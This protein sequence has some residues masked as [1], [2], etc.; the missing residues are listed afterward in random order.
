[1]LLLSVQ[2]VVALLYSVTAVTGLDTAGS[3]AA[4]VNAKQCN[5]VQGIVSNL[6]KTAMSSAQAFCNVY[7]TAKM[8]TVL[9]PGPTT[10]VRVAGICAAPSVPG[11]PSST[12]QVSKRD[13]DIAKRGFVRSPAA[14]APTFLTALGTSILSKACS[15]LTQT[16]TTVTAPTSTFTL[17]TYTPVVATTTK[18]FTVTPSANT[19]YSTAVSSRI[20]TST[21]TSVVSATSISETVI[22]NTEYSTATTLDIA[23][24][25]IPSPT[26]TSTET[27]TTVVTSTETELTTVVIVTTSRLL[28]KRA[29]PSSVLT[30]CYTSTLTVST[31]VTAAT[32]TTTIPVQSV[33]DRTTQQ[34]D[35][36]TT[37]TTITS[38]LLTTI[39]RPTTVTI[40][41]TSTSISGYV[42]SEST[43]ITFKSIST[44]TVSSTTTS[45]TIQQPLRTNLVKNPSFESHPGL[46]DWKFNLTGWY[47]D[48][49]EAADGVQYVSLFVRKDK[50]YIQD[51]AI[52]YQEIDSPYLAN[53][54]H[55][56]FQWKFSYIGDSLNAYIPPKNPVACTLIAGWKDNAAFT[57]TTTITESYGTTYFSSGK[58][59]QW[60]H[61]AFDIPPSNDVS[62]TLAFKFTCSSLSS[63]VYGDL[64]IDDTSVSVILPSVSDQ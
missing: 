36:S 32:P 5:L 2:A 31:T 4:A 46:T 34:I 16:I 23:T 41:T 28:Q 7:V 14:P 9:L 33:N 47:R 50:A 11:V 59:P 30:G 48:S 54:A 27:Y 26:A 1:M 19:A 57:N 21:M 25:V 17:T 43:L 39:T 53:G 40:P 29:V 15:C 44:L 38:T 45:T 62:G 63:S 8:Q 56:T 49:E 52:L 55:V 13:V 61:G 6:P 20:L 12:P 60:N 10:T 24:V 64:E 3:I 18:T 22:S 51:N 42:A 35:V 58:F 37:T